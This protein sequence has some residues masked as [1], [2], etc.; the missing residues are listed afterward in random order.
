MQKSKGA[1]FT[2]TPTKVTTGTKADMDNS[3]L[4][5]DKNDGPQVPVYVWATFTHKS[6]KPMAVS[7]MDDGLIV[8]T[9]KNRRTRALIVLLGQAKWPDCP[10]PDSEKQLSAGQSEK[11]C[12]VF[13]I[14]E[15][16]KAAAV[17]LS[18]GF[19]SA[20]LEWPVKD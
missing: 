11:I 4:Q 14:P 7:D 18:Q 20:P 15:G 1:K 13:L 3:G 5:K 10:A 6:G 9:D 17:E 16:Q 2:V 19:Y 12:K 8:R